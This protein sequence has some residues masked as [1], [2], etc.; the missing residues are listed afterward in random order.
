MSWTLCSWDTTKEKNHTGLSQG[1]LVAT[2]CHK[3]TQLPCGWRVPSVFL[4]QLFD[5]EQM[6]HH[7]S[8]I[9]AWKLPA[10]AVQR[11]VLVQVRVSFFIYH[12]EIPL[13]IEIAVF[14]RPELN[15]QA[16][17][18]GRQ[19]QLRSVI[20]MTKSGTE[21]LK[22]GFMKPPVTSHPHQ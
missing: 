17:S 12:L 21:A 22:Q 8:T 13:T 15:L 3:S 10:A 6:R 14:S 18:E 19:N 20:A 9:N 7:A 5:D 2:L 1:A 4:Q 11:L 16:L